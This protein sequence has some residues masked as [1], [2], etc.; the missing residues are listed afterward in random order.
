[1]E[2]GWIEKSKGIVQYM[3]QRHKS[4]VFAVIQ[5]PI[6]YSRAKAIVLVCCMSSG[7]LLWLP[8]VQGEQI[9]AW[10]SCL[11]IYHYTGLL[12]S[13]CPKFIHPLGPDGEN[14]IFTGRADTGLAFVH[15]TTLGCLFLSECPKVINPRTRWWKSYLYRVSCFWRPHMNNYR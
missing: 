2:T 1:M 11:R 14:P 6:V 7:S 8:L 5:I 12:Q 9:R 4:H 3:L 10:R 13:E 15:A